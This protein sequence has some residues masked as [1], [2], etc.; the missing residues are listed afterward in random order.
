MR[1]GC[2]LMTLAHNWDTYGAP[3]IEIETIMIGIKILLDHASP[4]SPSPAFVPTS[5]GGCQLEWHTAQV[6]LEI[7]IVPGGE[8]FVFYS[9]RKLGLSGEG[10]LASNSDRVRLM[11]RELA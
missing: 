4:T 11:L 5:K 2:D 8:A 6:D 10:D 7:E 3:P 9:D 1:S